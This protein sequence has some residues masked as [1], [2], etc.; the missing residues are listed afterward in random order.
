MARWPELVGV[1]LNLQPEPSNR[2]FGERSLCL[3]GRPWLRE[4][5]AGLEIRLDAVS[6]FQVNS[7]LA[8]AVV[9]L[10]VEALAGSEGLVI[11]A[12]C[13]IGTFSLPL[14]ERG[15]QVL[16]LEQQH[17]AVDLARGNA[18]RLALSGRAAFLA[19]DVAALLPV[20]LRE[21]QPGALLLDPPRKG[22]APEVLAAI[23]AQPPPRLLYLSC[24]P[25]TLARDLARLCDQEQGAYGPE[26][27]QPLDFFPNTSHI[28][29][30]AVLRR[31]H[32]G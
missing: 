3:A 16:G 10:L 9:P 5:F 14:A 18:E 23:S 2:L 21:R 11:D 7:R 8:E 31:R 25:A 17:A 1:T 32:A 24:D 4:R 28:E 19:G 22:L 29:C 20:Q 12:Y 30:L 13:G 27:V 15:W 26:W 6:F